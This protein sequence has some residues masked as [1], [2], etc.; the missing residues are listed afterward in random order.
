LALHTKGKEFRSS[1]LFFENIIV[2]NPSSACLP[3]KQI[4]LIYGFYHF[5]SCFSQVNCAIVS[6]LFSKDFYR[7]PWGWREARYPVLTPL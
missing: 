1:V 2:K 4:K 7:L 5:R 3:Q 6:A